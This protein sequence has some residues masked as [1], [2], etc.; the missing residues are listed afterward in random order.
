[1]FDIVF[2]Q[3]RLFYQYFVLIYHVL[4]IDKC[5]RKKVLVVESNFITT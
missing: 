4:N 2:R 1:M 3:H 5:M